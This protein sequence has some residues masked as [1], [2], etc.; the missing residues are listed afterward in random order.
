MYDYV[1]GVLTEQVNSEYDRIKE[2]RERD[3]EAFRELD[4]ATDADERYGNPLS[5]IAFH[6]YIFLVFSPSWNRLFILCM[7]VFPLDK[8]LCVPC[9]DFGFCGLR[10]TFATSRPMYQ[11]FYRITR[12]GRIY[13]ADEYRGMGATS[14]AI[15]RGDWAFV[16]SG[17]RTNHYRRRTHNSRRR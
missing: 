13:S 8:D 6:W 5:N 1:V 9:A 17:R 3:N 14:T 11:C 10:M 12:R 15:F 16:A 4:D 2:E 7:Y